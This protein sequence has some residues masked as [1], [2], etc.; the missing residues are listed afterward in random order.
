V[1]VLRVS[2][3][4]LTVLASSGRAQ[5]TGLA[6]VTLSTPALAA[7]DDSAHAAFRRFV[8]DWRRIHRA[9]GNTRDPGRDGGRRRTWWP[10][11][12]RW[13]VAAACASH[14]IVMEQPGH[15]DALRWRFR[16]FAP[17][18]GLI[19]AC[20]TALTAPVQDVVA[21]GTADGQLLPVYRPLARTVRSTLLTALS[22]LDRAASHRSELVSGLR[23]L[24]LLEQG[25]T[26]DAAEVSRACAAPR[27]WCET[28][29]RFAA[30]RNLPIGADAPWDFD[31]H[32]ARQ[33]WLADP[34]WIAPGN[35]RRAASFVRTIELKIR[36]RMG[37]DE[38]YN[39]DPRVRGQAL[40]AAVEHYGLPDYQWAMGSHFDRLMWWHL[41]KYPPARSIAPFTSMEYF[42]DR[43][44]LV[45][46]D[47]VLSNP[48]AGI[49]WSVVPPADPEVLWYPQESMRLPFGLD[50]LPGQLALFRRDESAVVAAAVELPPHAHEAPQR[51]VRL[52]AST[53]PDTIRE[54]ASQPLG[55]LAVL[56]LHG[57]VP[58]A[59]AVLGVEYLPDTTLSAAAG[60]LRLG[61]TMPPALHVHD[62][63][64]ALSTPVLLR[65]DVGGA[66]P[67]RHDADAF[68]ALAP[69]RTVRSGTPLVLYWE[70]YGVPLDS[71]VTHGVWVQ[72]T[73]RQGTIMR[74]G[75]RLNLRPDANTPIAVSWP[76]AGLGAR[77]IAIP[78][79]HTTVVGRSMS[80][81][82]T[83]LAPGRYRV[84][85]SIAR[86]D[87]VILLT[88][89][90]VQITP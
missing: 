43:V 12:S 90:D 55:T 7:I 33:W 58:F 62:A 72:R 14:P 30:L 24:M 57:S 80:V 4:L 21:D 26:E 60:R 64:P 65:D 40:A 71:T 56:A 86:D 78:S 31:A 89:T 8:W 20:P 10:P 84:G 49:P 19:G 52:V 47:S 77:A 27:D 35:E 48:F 69:T 37:L 68:A 23:V 25:Q 11:H 87:R 88:S 2:S 61:L 53:G 18:S 85:V 29:Q 38:Y 3:V 36:R 81:Q 1:R 13:M 32:A 16:T 66:Q 83:G 22:T 34:L 42:R 9:S 75:I 6:P 46:P 5:E 44:A 45:P 73:D 54:V 17:E 51:T 28:L 50:E 15:R 41:T 79:R 82:T 74:I 70:S 67:L 39:W 63:L 59:Q 76:D